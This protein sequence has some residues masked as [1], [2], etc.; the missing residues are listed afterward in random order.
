MFLILW[1]LDSPRP[2]NSYAF[3]NFIDMALS[4][5][6]RFRK[7]AIRLNV[8]KNQNLEIRMEA[9]CSLRVCGKCL[10]QLISI[11]RNTSQSDQTENSFLL[12][13]QRAAAIW[14]KSSFR[15]DKITISV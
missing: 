9:K 5:K 10:G 4:I 7:G 13:R 15:L 12:I 6:R 8:A 3:L 2:V 1:V 14:Q 11:K